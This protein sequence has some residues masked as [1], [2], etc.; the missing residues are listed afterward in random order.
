[1][2]HTES[3]H[4]VPACLQ[5]I[6]PAVLPSPRPAA[7][8]QTPRH[9]RPRRMEEHGEHDISGCCGRCGASGPEHR[10]LVGSSEVE[11]RHKL[12]FACR[13]RSF[14]MV[15]TSSLRRCLIWEGDWSPEIVTVASEKGRRGVYGKIVLTVC[16]EVRVHKC[17]RLIDVCIFHCAVSNCWPAAG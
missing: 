7:S 4:D 11:G 13:K 5:Q 3:L 15:K 10:N 8:P 1:M 16:G 14:Q 2:C 12:L 6:Q 17:G 9:L